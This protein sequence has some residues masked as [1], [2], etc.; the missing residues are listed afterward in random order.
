MARSPIFDSLR[1]VTRLCAL[2]LREGAP[3]LDELIQVREFFANQRTKACTRRE[4]LRASALSGAALAGG[5]LLAPPRKATVAPG[6]PRIVLVGAGIAGLNAAY[7]LKQAGLRAEVYEAAD[8]VGGRIFTAKDL[9]GPGL[10]TEIGGEF[11]DTGHAEMRALANEFHLDLFDL[12]SPSETSLTPFAFFFG[13]RQYTEAQAVKEYAALAER[14]RAD[15]G[16]LGSDVNFENHNRAAESLDRMSIAE[17]FDRI[18]AGGWM[19]KLLE[20]AYVTENGLECGEQSALNFITFISTDVS[21]GYLGLS[22][23]SD[24]RYKVKG[25]NQRIVDELAR[26]LENQIHRRQ[27]LEAIKSKGKG[28]T[29]TFESVNGTAA[30]VDA[31]CV[32]MCIPFTILREVDVRVELPTVKRKAIQE[33]GYGTNA[34]VFIGFKD[35]HWRELGYTGAAI[36]DEAFQAAWDNSEL[37]EGSAGGL[38]L[39]S[40]G[41]SGIEVGK[42]TPQEVAA[43]LVPGVEKVFPGIS[44]RLDGKASRFHWPTYRWTKGSYSSYKPGQWTALRGSEAKPVGNLFFAGEHCSADFQ[45]FMNGGAQSGKD[46]AQALLAAL[47][48]KAAAS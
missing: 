28:Y 38:T 18:G 34:K 1:R 33:L 27:R 45:G 2:A 10:T 25:G 9:L 24:T 41:K 21:S 36:S 14:I 17:Y 8:R 4:F 47:G 35:R 32:V 19:R 5:N 37:Q 39:F 7:K 26:R 29:L 15:L 43:R 23:D 31:D 42:G 16:S 20:V 40:G 30:D 44:K 6:G 48:V 12:R 3:P 13:G 11:I 22:G 46:A